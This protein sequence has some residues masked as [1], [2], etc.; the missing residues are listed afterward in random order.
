MRHV[1]IQ[2]DSHEHIERTVETVDAW[3]TIVVELIKTLKPG[4]IITL[5]GKLGAGKTTLVQALAHALHISKT[6]Q[7]P[8]F[9]LLHAYSL[10]ESVHGITR[11]IH[12]DAYRID[13]EKDLFA[14][15]L[16]TELSD[17]QSILVIE[18]PEKIPNWIQQH[19]SQVIKINIESVL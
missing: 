15:D 11:L 17:E 12:V 16:D 2:Q 8:T 19:N 18:W 9:A 13:D 1:T 3:R 7:S 6:P 5:S 14:L 10:P 4:T